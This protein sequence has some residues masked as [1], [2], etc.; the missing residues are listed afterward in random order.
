M[1]LPWGLVHGAEL[2]SH[3]HKSNSYLVPVTPFSLHEANTI[4]FCSSKMRIPETFVTQRRS[5]PQ[6]G[7]LCTATTYSIIQ[8]ITSYV[9]AQHTLWMFKGL[10]ETRCFSETVQMLICEEDYAARAVF[11]RFPLSVPL[12]PAEVTLR[13]HSCFM[14]I[15]CHQRTHRLD[16]CW[17]L[18]KTR[19]IISCRA[20]ESG[21]SLSQ[22]NT[23]GR[24]VLYYC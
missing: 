1:N 20:S 10:R 4:C 6:Y 15:W 17:F 18:I 11:G 19:S 7:S 23:A 9:V 3:Q 5:L 24:S 14:R 8:F 21:R 13:K 12:S 16:R 22:W 2:N